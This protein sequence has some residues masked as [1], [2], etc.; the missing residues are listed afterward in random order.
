MSRRSLLLALVQVLLVF[1]LIGRY[2]WDRARYPRA[3]FRALPYDP[4]LPIR[5]RYLA[6]RLV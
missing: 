3:W 6:L 5:G 1:G 2:A 4:N